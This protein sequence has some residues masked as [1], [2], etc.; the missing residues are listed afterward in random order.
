MIKYIYKKNRLFMTL[1][2]FFM[3]VLSA[4]FTF[5]SYFLTYM[6]DL[7]LKN[8]QN[9][10]ITV[11][12][13]QAVIL[14][15]IVFPLLLGSNIVSQHFEFIAERNIEKD[16]ARKLIKKHQSTS[17]VLNIYNKDI[18]IITEK[19]ISNIGQSIYIVINFLFAFTYLS[20][21]SLSI[22]LIISATVIVLVIIN[23]FFA[24]K[25]A[26][27]LQKLQ[28]S[29]AN[30]IRIVNGVFNCI[31]T[32]NIFSAQE[33]ILK[34]LDNSFEN[35]L[36]R[37]KNYGV[38]NSLMIGINGFFS[39]A[40]QM[41]AIIASFIFVY[42]NKMTVG[43]VLSIITLLSY[44]TNPLSSLMQCK[45]D[46]DS[47]KNIRIKLE[48]ILNEQSNEEI[49]EIGE[50]AIVFNSVKFS[51]DENEFIDDINL[52]FLM[53]GKYLIVGESG[54]GKSTLLKLI[55]KEYAPTS[56]CI[57]YNNKNI[58]DFNAPTWYNK[59]GYCSQKVEIL[60]G[61]IT[62]NIVLSEKYDNKKLDSVVKIL[63]LGYLRDKFDNEIN[64]S[65]SNFSGGE[66]QRIAIARML[67]KNAPILLFDEFTSSLDNSNSFKIE[68]ELLEINNKLIIN[69]SHRIHLVLLEKYDKILIMD[70]GKIKCFGNYKDV[71]DELHLYVSNEE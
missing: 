71:V 17:E 42:Y 60:P 66:L 18:K 48:N 23:Q 30:M 52:E 19:Y 34:K 35:K 25:L 67:Y 47:T 12:I 53:N 27:S 5:R 16:I 69:V 39:F 1:S 8:D 55:L 46:M 50:H 59:I 41:G 57:S 28:K 44:I 56:G 2:L 7:L 33:F 62:E 40:I 14:V 51:Y 54:S 26:V 31:Q 49:K 13:W 38:V 43:Q 37:N 32:I 22:V 45:N 3:V 36:K 58:I 20:S 4:Y 65:I 29:N 6:T 24:K 70:K 15:V 10:D 68:K 9:I 21:I 61:T 11:V 64:E 63:N